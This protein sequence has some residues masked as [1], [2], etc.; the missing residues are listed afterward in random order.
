[1]ASSKE[2]QM[3]FQLSA[4]MNGGF[5]STF[6]AGQKAVSELQQQ[7]NALN[8]TQSDISAYQ[9]QQSALDKSKEK[10]ALY[11]SQ[12]E[13]LKSVEAGSA[14]EAAHLANEIEAKQLQ[15]NNAQAAVDKNNEKL[16]EMGQ[17]LREAG[18]DTNNL[19]SES[20]RLKA[21]T[22]AV[23]DEQK[24][25]A[26]AAQ[27]AG[28]S[29]KDAMQ[30]AA[31]AIEA[32]GLIR[33]FQQVYSALMDCSTAAA[34][35]ETAMAGVKR[36][37]GGDDS[38]I[39]SLGETFKDL[40]T[41]M[42]ITASELAGIATTAGQ[43]GIAQANVESFTTVMAQL[44][45][46]TDLSADNAATMLAQFSNITGVTD[47]ARLGS[48]VAA[49]GD[50]TATTASKVVEMSQG[51]A[52]AASIAGMSSTDILAISAAV[53]SLGIEAA[54]GSTSMSQLISTLYKATETGNNLEEFASV[55]G[56]SAQEFKTAW[57]QDA[58]GALD[59]FIQG[60][61]DTE[62]NGKSA[63]VI[64][65]ELGI[66]NVRQTKAIL[67]L[68]SA[69]SLLSDT[70]AQANTAWNENSALAEKAGVM[71]GT[72]EAKMTMMQNAANNVSIA[73]GDALNPALSA[74]YD[75][76]T[77]LLQPIA[78]FIEQ[79]PAVVQGVT[80][81]VGVLG[82]ATVAIT[83]Y[84]AVTKLAAAASTLFAGAIPGLGLI[85][86]VAGA[87][88]A[89]VGVISA[90][91]G[92]NA[93][94][95]KSFEELNTEFDDLQ[96]QF[97][98]NQKTIDL[99]D[100]YKDLE[101]EATNLQKLFNKDFSTEVS[102]SGKVPDDGKL[103]SDDFIDGSTTVKLTPDKAKTLAAEGFLDGSIVKLT[104]EQEK[105][106]AGQSF[107]ETQF[108]KLTPEQEK[109][110][111][112]QEFLNNTKVKLTPE[113]AEYM[114]GKQFMRDTKVKL[115]P[116]QQK[117][118]KSQE[119][120][121][122]GNV[123]E[124][125]PH[126]FTT[127]AAQGF[128]TD[129][130]AQVELTGTCLNTMAA[131]NLLSGTEVEL[132]GTAGKALASASLLD[133]STVTLTAEAK[134]KLTQSA[135][136]T[137]S[138][139]ITFT[140]QADPT[141]KLSAADFGI[142]E[143]TLIYI[144]QMDATSYKDVSDKAK[145]LG[146]D[147]AQ[148]RSDLT[149]ASSTLSE[150]QTKYSELETQLTKTR[151]TKQKGAI[152]EQMEE[153][154]EQITEQ[155]QKV[156]A[157]NTKY[158]ELETE[159]TV[160]ATAAGEL[161]GK[162]ET[163]LA[164]KQAL[165]DASEGVITASAN[166]TEAFNQQAT[167]AQAA[168]DANLALIRSKMYEN[169]GQQARQ[170]KTAVTQAAEAEA[171]YNAA[172][173][174]AAVV[175]KYAGMRAEEVNAAYQSLL[176]T[177]DNMEAAEGW[178]PDD[179]AYRAAA[180]EAEH[181][182]S[183]F[184]GENLDI[185]GS[186][187]R[188]SEG[189]VNWVDSQSDLYT[190]GELWNESIESI[191]ANVAEYKANMEDAQKT[192]SDFIDNLSQ[193][194][195]TGAMTDEQ[196]R[197]M[198]ANS[199]EGEADAAETVEAIMKDVNAQINAEAAAAEEAAAATEEL[200]NAT[201]ELNES[202]ET[203]LRSIDEITADID[204]LVK[205][206]DDAYK[207][208]KESMEGQ[209]KLFDDAKTVTGSAKGA[210]GYAKNL[211]NQSKYIEQYTDNYET[212]A[213][214]L[215]AA[216]AEIVGSGNAG[217]EGASTSILSQLADGSAESAQILADLAT[218]SAEDIKALVEQY[219]T[220]Q[221]TKDSYAKT[222]AEIETNFDEGMN[223]LQ[224]ELETTVANLGFSTDAATNASNSMAAFTAAISAATGPAAAAAAALAQA[225]NDKLKIKF[226][227]LP[228]FHFASGTDEAPPGMALVGENGPELVMLNGGEQILNASE[229]RAL[230][231]K[232]ERAE[233]AEATL[234]D[235][236]SGDGGGKTIH[237]DF[238]PQYTITGSTNADELRAVLEENSVNLKEQI[239]Q[240]L[241]EIE[242]DDDRRDYT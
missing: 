205:S 58:V 139:T 92:A 242:E 46:T 234:A 64:L 68:A 47:Y 2:Y 125:T 149:T 186:A 15:V 216:E 151:S 184:A 138:K 19:A 50:S 42:P 9:K 241:A 30:G 167:A 156:Q 21:E 172:S 188:L 41:Q 62:R 160:A 189:M 221:T 240:I 220:L 190:T 96:R 150:M 144:A 231:E 38:F 90:I 229:T 107:L 193:A 101:S 206:Y 174:R 22:A 55:A 131:E 165:A 60:L 226:S 18:V 227:G 133:N 113:Q 81:F 200:A 228:G 153:L 29:M 49:L 187:D 162:E 163:L 209:F 171:Q 89:L 183:I 13:R 178:T 4:S 59:A 237:V 1:M 219:T 5:S 12:L 91:T 198:L 51:M 238:N 82:V 72:T 224:T 218:A 65:D 124:L 137:D 31:A 192:Q 207:A 180:Q 6:S 108:V 36:T 196:V 10:L 210:Q 173:E 132:T 175:Q 105:F 179:E 66:T 33:G 83:G 24:K 40:S 204:A 63:V 129:G 225:V 99:I 87:I 43:L 122:G 202:S 67:G 136:Y 157:L 3:L 23:A 130:N 212:A 11:Q 147:L 17:A 239:E 104:P 109:Y 115:T 128:L 217:A 48:T 73:V 230:M 233:P 88:G 164:A 223:E 120:L 80:A 159:Y 27:E 85:L 95:S 28:Q 16:S 143:Q 141:K 86:G 34:Q 123:I 134:E 84:T 222:V 154:G 201:E 75:A 127:L 126:Q 213:A 116:E 181:L 112:G 94:A 195:T 39:N 61:N 77:Q 54:S 114:S 111:A 211:E 232:A 110:L 121:E 148:T 166:E 93:E 146:T 118:L 140:P 106:L 168:A 78:D 52:A 20:E 169:A 155:T 203:H 100:T 71:Y 214:A 35:F 208:A 97:E 25:E 57:G 152:Q 98:D 182:A 8:R 70:V 158:G 79:N 117:F 103:T 145:A 32:A 176:V 56:M 119:F 102:F 37:V 236:G 215:K 199:L 177:L 161:S 194:I 235:S 135:F 53:G 74:V 7:I 197:A 170:Y 26:E 142:S 14:S 191:N 76:A 45:T 44:A 69:G 185:L